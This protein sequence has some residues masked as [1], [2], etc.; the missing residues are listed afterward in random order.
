MEILIKFIGILI[1]GFVVLLLVNGAG[2][3]L[4]GLLPKKL[5]NS[6]YRILLPLLILSI[7]GHLSYFVFI[8]K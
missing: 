5:R 2:Y 7:I 1:I 6:R 3:V 8:I 4:G